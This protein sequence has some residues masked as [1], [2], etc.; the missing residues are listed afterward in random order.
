[1]H[2][3]KSIINKEKLEN[4]ISKQEKNKRN[5]KHYINKSESLLKIDSIKILNDISQQIKRLQNKLN[6]ENKILMKLIK[7][8]KSD[9]EKCKKT[10]EKYKEMENNLEENLEKKN[11]VK[12]RK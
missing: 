9:S 3:L 2:V 6:L 1:M 8:K 11:K 5:E 10:M 7:Q 12:R 4:I